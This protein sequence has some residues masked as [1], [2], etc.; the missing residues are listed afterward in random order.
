[1]SKLPRRLAIYGLPVA[2]M[3]A[4]MMLFL[5]RPD[6]VLPTTLASKR[7]QC[8]N[9]LKQIG[10]GLRLYH[11]RYKSLPPAF[12]VGPDGK[13]WH[14]WRMLILPFMEGDELV[15][16]YRLDEPWDGPNNRHLFNQCP[17]VYQCPS[18]NQALA[19]SATHYVAVLGSQTLWLE[20]AATVRLNEIKDE[21]SQTITV[22]EVPHAVPW[23]APVDCSFQDAET[24][25]VDIDALPPSDHVAG[26]N[27]LMADGTVRF[28][29]PKSTSREVWTAL[30]TRDG[31]ETIP[32]LK[33]PNT[34]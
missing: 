16:K 11:D 3:A 34:R 15:K 21:A 7:S 6:E 10:L 25:W 26:R 2:V 9:N 13:R 8:K 5:S 12:V 17:E 30:F 18:S 23:L 29:T 32:E 14:S 1:M 19:K 28:L 31:G 27:V 24:L 20:D 33:S 4:G 22:M